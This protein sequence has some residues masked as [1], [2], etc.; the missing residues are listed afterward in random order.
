[1]GQ[2]GTHYVYFIFVS[3]TMQ[4]LSLI[5]QLLS[6][7][8]SFL[9][10][11]IFS[12]IHIVHLIINGNK[13][14]NVGYCSVF[15]KFI[16]CYA[17]LVLP[18]FLIWFVCHLFKTINRF[19]EILKPGHVIFQAVCFSKHKQFFIHLKTLHKSLI[20]CKKQ[21]L[22]QIFI[23]RRCNIYVTILCQTFR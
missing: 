15:N 18:T 2:Y 6:F 12:N 23:F 9:F 19:E 20:N 8:V 11:F 13:Q 21:V 1:M 7:L 5:M 4:L 22:L 17:G 10:Y 3:H 16:S 14:H